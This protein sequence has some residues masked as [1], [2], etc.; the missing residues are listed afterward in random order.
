[1]SAKCRHWRCKRGYL[2]TNYGGGAEGQNRTGDT[3][4]FS[5][6]LYRLSYLGG[7]FMLCR[8][9]TAVKANFTAE[10]A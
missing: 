7:N 2:A 9:T 3:S 4:V 6:V 1:M 10:A 5:A 8:R